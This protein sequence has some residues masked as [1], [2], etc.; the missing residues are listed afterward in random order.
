MNLK[1]TLANL[2]AIMCIITLFPTIKS[3]AISSSAKAHAV[4]NA[5]SGELIFGKN[6]DARLPMASTTKIMTA[7]LLCE[8][9][10]EN[11]EIKATREM[12][13][14]E[15]SSMGLLEGD[16]V[17]LKDLLYGMMLA[18]GNDAANTAAIVV[19]GSVENFVRLMN[20]RAKEI[21][22]L[23]TSFETPSGLDGEN[24]YTT[25]KELALLAAFAMKNDR[26]RT[27]ASTVS[28]TAFYG[29]PPYKRTIKNHNRLLKTYEGL[30]GVKTGFTKKSGRCL[31]TSA[32]RDGKEIIVVT[33]NDPNDWQDHKNLL[34]AGFDALTTVKAKYEKDKI[35]INVVGGK[36]DYI[37]IEIPEISVNC[38]KDGTIT[39]EVLAPSFL[40]APVK[41]DERIAELL[42][43]LNGEVYKSVPLYAKEAIGVQEVKP[44]IR[45]LKQFL[46]IFFSL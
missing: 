4:I 23:N 16:I 44:Q 29:N 10:N 33:L 31:V 9:G 24:H 20:K 43:Y 36:S 11:R 3:G 7:L 40:Y 45:F 37:T 6:E 21:G 25:A 18:S 8:Y 35:K 30:N 1:K 12:V 41:R 17:T 46:A 26:F 42:V 19:G 5:E 14:V 28:Y 15:G 39:T 2:L 27:A 13:A 32:C 22:L 38:L 34:D